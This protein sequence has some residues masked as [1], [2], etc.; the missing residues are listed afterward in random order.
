M[1]IANDQEY[2]DEA[3]FNEVMQGTFDLQLK[4]QNIKYLADTD[5]KVI[6]ELERMYLLGTPINL[7]R[8]LIRDDII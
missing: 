7:E 2:T 5:W 4:E 3:E 8:E 1:F 6:R